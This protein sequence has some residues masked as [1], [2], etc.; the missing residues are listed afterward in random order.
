MKKSY[1]QNKH[2][3]KNLG[4]LMLGLLAISLGSGDVS[5]ERAVPGDYD[6]DK[7]TDIIV[8]RGIGNFKHW[9][10]RFSNGSFNTPFIF[11]LSNDTEA[12]ADFY[13]DGK[14]RPAV[15]R[16]DSNGFVTWFLLNTAGNIE[17][18]QFGLKDDLLLGA[19]MDQ[20]E[21]ADH[22]A[23]RKLL[24]GL[25]WFALLSSNSTIQSFQWGLAS[26][27]PFLADVDGNSVSDAIVVRNVGSFK[28]WF[29]RTDSGTGRNPVLFGLASDTALQPVDLDG[30][31]IADF[32]V[33]RNAG[34][35]S[36]IFVRLN[37][38][39][40]S[41]KG[42]SSFQFG[43]EKDDLVFGHHFDEGV[44]NVKAFRR[45]GSGA[46]ATSFV[47]FPGINAQSLVGVP[48]GLG[49]DTLIS[50]QGLPVKT[51]EAAVETPG[52]G[53]GLDSVCSSTRPAFSGF[54]W[55]PASTHSGGTREGR[56]MVAWKA[57]PPTSKSCIKVYAQNGQQVSQL[58]LYISGGKYGARWYTGWGCGDQKNAS[59]VA[60]AANNAAG[61]TRIYLEGP[62][63]TC[64][65]PL[66]PTARNGNL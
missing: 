19:H 33:R 21:K 3:T 30:D 11:G 40:G 58:G 37:N 55:K 20:D 27:T 2:R 17:Q 14:F 15:T 56:P 32:P 29:V 41:E 8:T 42:V 47:R 48:F 6:G 25:T 62:A 10:A 44:A 18:R 12:A 38:S 1:Y 43:L 53:A 22:V 4:A 63:R 46:Q 64:I 7:K 26:D 52:V 31:G 16:P 50:P 35:F 54:L 39:D 61:S 23:V 13:G 45:G 65:G 36:Q 28:H 60:S 59:Q 5:A 66:N 49:G 51:A 24:G 34:G 57:G 9:F